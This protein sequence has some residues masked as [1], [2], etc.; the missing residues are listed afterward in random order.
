[1]PRPAHTEPRQRLNLD[2][3]QRSRARLERLRLTSDADTM[4]EVIRR[5]LILY[6]EL[7]TTRDAGGQILLR[8]GDTVREVLIS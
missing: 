2:M 3:A 1:M 8:V 5:A 7:L 4:T 6:E